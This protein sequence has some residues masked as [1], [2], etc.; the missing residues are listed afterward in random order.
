MNTHLLCRR[1]ELL[2]SRIALAGD[3]TAQLIGGHLVI[4]G[5]AQANAF[6]IFETVGGTISAVAYV[7]K[8]LDDSTT[9]NGSSQPFTISGVTRDVR[10]SLGA[11]DDLLRVG[12]TGESFRALRDL[13]ISG[14]DGDN[15]IELHSSGSFVVKGDIVIKNGA[16]DDRVEARSVSENH[17]QALRGRL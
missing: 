3:V 9:I 11:G 6:E 8:S 16:G 2:E 7:L 4:T 14:G 13:K 12:K 15:A 5:D 10:I 17:W 1:V